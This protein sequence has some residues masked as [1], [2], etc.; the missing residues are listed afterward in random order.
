MVEYLGI[1]IIALPITAA[2]LYFVLN[3]KG[4]SMWEQPQ[5]ENV[6]SVGSFVLDNPI[7]VEVK[8]VEI[9]EIKK[10]PVKKVDSI[11]KPKEIKEEVKKDTSKTD[12]LEQ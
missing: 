11:V 2:I 6:D 3:K 7:K 10:E 4:N 1:A 5:I 12:I 9:P 8:K